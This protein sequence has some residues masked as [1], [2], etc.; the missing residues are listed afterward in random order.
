MSTTTLPK[1][2]ASLLQNA[3]RRICGNSHASH[4]AQLH[5]AL[6]TIHHKYATEDD[7]KGQEDRHPIEAQRR[8]DGGGMSAIE[9]HNAYNDRVKG[10]R[11]SAEEAGLCEVAHDV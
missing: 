2:S 9:G 3:N 4:V 10:D 11:D 7:D 1:M 8:P 5:L 6:A